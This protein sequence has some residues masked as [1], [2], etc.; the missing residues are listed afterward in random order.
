MA[1]LYKRTI[2]DIDELNETI[3]GYIHWAN[4]RNSPPAG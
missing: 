1:Y 3:P 2:F 4:N